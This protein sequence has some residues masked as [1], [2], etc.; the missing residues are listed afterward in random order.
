[1]KAHPNP[2]PVDRRVEAGIFQ[3]REGYTSKFEHFIESIKLAQE[4]YNKLM[5]HSMVAKTP[6]DLVSAW[7]EFAQCRMA[8]VGLVMNEAMGSGLDWKSSVARA[9]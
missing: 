7:N 6:I 1:M 2:E 9:E 5:Q 4:D 8:H 3:W